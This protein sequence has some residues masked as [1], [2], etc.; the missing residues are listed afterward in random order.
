MTLMCLMGYSPLLH[1]PSFSNCFGA[2]SSL[3][4]KYCSVSNYFMRV[5]AIYI[6]IYSFSLF[7]LLYS[8]TL[9]FSFASFLFP[10]RFL[11]LFSFSLS[12]FRVKVVSLENYSDCT[13]SHSTSWVLFIMCVHIYSENTDLGLLDYG[14]SHYGCKIRTFDSFLPPI[15]QISKILVIIILANAQNMHLQ[16]GSR[17]W[18]TSWLSSVQS[19]SWSASV[20][21]ETGK[22]VGYDRYTLAGSG[23]HIGCRSRAPSH[24]IPWQTK[25][26]MLMVFDKKRRGGCK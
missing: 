20:L 5:Y 9:T 16:V 6:Y 12:S 4:M 11:F 14:K 23:L 25:E 7:S 13:V 2:C 24:K 18:L 22:A 10:S 1:T 19:V 26:V 3:C 17:S 15:L 21:Q 8:F